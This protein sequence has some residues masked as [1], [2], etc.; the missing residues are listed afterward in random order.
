[1]NLPKITVITVS[2]NSAQTIEK[3][4]KS[5]IEQDYK[6]KEY[7]IIDGNSIDGTTD[8]IKRYGKYIS[9]FVS[10]K[11]KGISD[12]FNKGIAL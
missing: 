7:I 5:V 9:A 1:M 2:Y 11:D 10:E 3:T 4:I 8:I 12:A 6:N